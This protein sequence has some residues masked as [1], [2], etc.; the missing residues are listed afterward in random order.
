MVACIGIGILGDYGSCSCDY[1]HLEKVELLHNGEAERQT[2][3]TPAP[4]AAG[5]EGVA[6]RQGEGEGSRFDQE[7][8]QKPA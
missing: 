1:P 4:W 6:G 2:R 5:G 3:T 8:Q 7:G